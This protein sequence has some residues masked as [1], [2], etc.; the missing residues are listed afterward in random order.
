MLTITIPPQHENTTIVQPQ[1]KVKKLRFRITKL[2]QSSDEDV[3]RPQVFE[4]EWIDQSIPGVVTNGETVII[5]RCTSGNARQI[6]VLQLLMSRMNPHL[7]FF[8]H[9]IE[10]RKCHNEDKIDVVMQYGGVDLFTYLFDRGQWDVSATNQRISRTIKIFSKALCCLIKLHSLGLYHGD[11]K[12]ENFVIDPVMQNVQLIDFECTPAT[13]RKTLDLRPVSIP[14]GTAMY[15]HPRICVGAQVDGFEA[16]MWSFGQTVF[17]LYVGR[18]LFDTSSETERT[19]RQ[20]AFYV[21]HNWAQIYRPFF[22][23]HIVNHSTFE[24]FVDFVNL[25]CVN[26]NPQRPPRADMMLLQHPFLCAWRK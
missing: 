3:T 4:G 24:L 20:N 21:H 11:I 2:I 26:N 19:I 1:T 16:D 13:Q 15:S 10:T 6:D 9:V 22:E 18:S 8:P 14:M 5:K 23:D 7:D 25:M 12:P 17:A